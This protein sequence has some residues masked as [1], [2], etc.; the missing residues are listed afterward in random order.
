[1]LICPLLTSICIRLC[2]SK[3]GCS[4]T[5][6]SMHEYPCTRRCS[7]VRS[8]VFVPLH[9]YA[10]TAPTLRARDDAHLYKIG[11]VCSVTRVC[12]RYSRRLRDRHMS[13]HNK[14]WDFF[15]EQNLKK[16]TLYVFEFL[17]LN[18]RYMTSATS[19]MTVLT[20]HIPFLFY[21]EM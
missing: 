13:K 12:T 4:R 14:A 9:V 20:T 1:M 10:R 5:H 18:F 16:H 21:L 7:S 19:D 17:L 11:R 6:S 2:M 3:R 15:C 8:V